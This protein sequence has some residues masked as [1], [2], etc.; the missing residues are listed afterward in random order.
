MSREQRNAALEAE[1]QRLDGVKDAYLAALAEP[2]IIGP[3]AS[4]I[5]D[6]GAGAVSFRA[7]LR[8]RTGLIESHFSLGKST[9]FPP[10]NHL[11]RRE[12][13]FASDPKDHRGERVMRL[14]LFL[15]SSGLAHRGRRVVGYTKLSGKPD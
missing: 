13:A 11:H 6:G 2:C 4:S 1:P 9:R 7:V 12:W 8:W 10:Q 5:M 3:P 14:R 15:A